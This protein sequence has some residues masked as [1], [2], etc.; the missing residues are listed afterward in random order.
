MNGSVSSWRRQF[1]ERWLARRIPPARSVVLDQRRIF[2]LPS[3]TGLFFLIVLGVMLLAAINYQNNMAFALV[4]FLFSLFIVVILHTY[5]NLSGLRIEALRGHPTFAGEVAEFDI[6]LTRGDTRAYHA[7]TLGWPGQPFASA[8]LIDTQN[9]TV[10]LFHAAP[11]RGWL[12]PARLSLSTVYPLGLLRA[13]TWIDLDITALVYPRPLESARPH[14]GENSGADGDFLLRQGS[15]DF[16]DFRVYRP[17]D[18]LRHVLWRAYAKGQPLHSKQFAEV[19]MQ[20]HWLRYDG[21]EGDCERRLSILCFWVLELQRRNEQFGLELPGQQLPP[22]H[23]EEHTQ[24]ALQLL[25]LFNLSNA[26]YGPS[27]TARGATKGIS[28]AARTAGRDRPETACRG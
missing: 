28:S 11:R 20:S 15:E 19:A 16:Y 3:R 7:I 18:N 14:G 24:H 27:T 6:Q 12:R 4:F 8:S 21:L 26:A 5:S 1:H 10:K 25:A 23:G 17:G 13:W 22:G 9:V 2:I